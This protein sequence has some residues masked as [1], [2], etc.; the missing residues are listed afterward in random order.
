MGRRW[1]NQDRERQ[2]VDGFI[3]GIRDGMEAHFTAFFGG[4]GRRTEHSMD[5]IT[6]GLE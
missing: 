5:F 4:L 3:N 1:R 6:T 2:P